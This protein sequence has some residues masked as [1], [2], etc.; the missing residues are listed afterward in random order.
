MNTNT[1][2]RFR[3]Q[4]HKTLFLQNLKHEIPSCDFKFS[5]SSRPP[6]PSASVIS[7]FQ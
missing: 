1:S 5:P 3:A 7:Y 6:C 4:K 2:I